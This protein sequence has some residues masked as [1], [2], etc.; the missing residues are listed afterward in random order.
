MR[1][2]RNAESNMAVPDLGPLDTKTLA[3]LR[4]HAWDRNFYN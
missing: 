2:V 1:S 4:H 3:T